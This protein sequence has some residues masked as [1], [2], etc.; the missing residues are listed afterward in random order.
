MP[1]VPTQEP[2][3]PKEPEAAPE[4]QD[5]PVAQEPIKELKQQESVEKQESKE[6][7]AVE[8]PEQVSNKIAVVKTDNEEPEKEAAPTPTANTEEK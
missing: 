2:I 7:E 3:K 5:V 4:K 6:A 8:K 1:A